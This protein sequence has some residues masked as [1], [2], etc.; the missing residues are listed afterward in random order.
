L[1]VVDTTVL[2]YAAGGEHALKEPSRRLIDAIGVG[3][4]V[5]TTT[6]EVVQEFAYVFARRRPRAVAVRHARRYAELLSPLLPVR[7]LGLDYG[8]ALFEAH[9]RLGCFDAVL[10]AAALVEGAE[11]LVSADAGFAD[12]VGLNH[13][14][15]GSEAFD[16][17]VPA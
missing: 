5:A 11:A 13:V 6:V 9:P 4:V 2:M 12:V 17:L 10:A 8:L 14:V 1:I 3:R 7:P 16:E 15:P